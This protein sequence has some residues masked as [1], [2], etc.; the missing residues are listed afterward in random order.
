MRTLTKS[1]T[2]ATPIRRGAFPRIDPTELRGFERVAVPICDLI[3]TSGLVKTVVLFFARHFNTTWINAA[4]GRLQDLHGL[5]IPKGLAPTRGV[6]L[7]SNHRSFFDMY[8]ASA[9]LY[10]HARFMRR[11]YFPVRANTWFTHPLG[12]LVNLVLS[13]GAMWPPVFRDDRRFRLNPVGIAQMTHALDQPGAVLGIHPEGTR[14]KGPDPY[15]IQPARPG[16]GHL[17]KA[18]DP[19]T[20]ILP[21]FVIGL[22][23]D[24]VHEVRRNFKPPG[25]RGPP[26]RITF[27]EAV[28]AGSLDR[29]AG[30]QEIAEALL[31]RV[32]DLA[33]I[34]R[35]RY[36]GMGNC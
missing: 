14:G 19:E 4:T 7:I 27:G 21:F 1:E 35:E 15:E 22:S 12:L 20:L 11:I 9:V 36:G 18:A 25:R 26:V 16:V 23:N 33:R 13:G 29:E 6:I 30:A 31:D 24:V 28:R 2:Q 10:R 3:N 8:V 17:V 32:R 5:E 34:D